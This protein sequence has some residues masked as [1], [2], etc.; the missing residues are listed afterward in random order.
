MNRQQLIEENMNLVH[1]AISKYYPN[2]L[3]DEDLV[4]CGMIGLCIAAD[5]WEEGRSAF[6]TYA[7][8]CILHEFYKEFRRRCKLN[9]V[10]SLNYPIRNEDG[11]TVDSGDL[12]VGEEDVDFVDSEPFFN[13]L[14]PTEQRIVK[15]KQL[16]FTTKEIANHLGCSVSNVTQ[17]LRKLRRVWRL[18]YGD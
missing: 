15:Y 8:S 7:T 6:S 13:K 4:Q 16:G 3:G 2:S 14:S 17:Y 12:V 10:W 9:E 5:T 18:T 1:F 11:N